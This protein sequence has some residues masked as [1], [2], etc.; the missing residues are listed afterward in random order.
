MKPHVKY[1]LHLGLVCAVLYIVKSYIQASGVHGL[2]TLL[3]YIGIAFIIN[4]GVKERRAQ[5]HGNL[6]Y[7]E[8]FGTGM[9]ITLIGSAIASVAF[10]INLKFFNRDFFSQDAVIKARERVEDMFADKFSDDE[11]QHYMDISTGPGA[12]SFGPFLEILITGLIVSLI[13]AAI[14]KHG[15]KNPMLGDNHNNPGMRA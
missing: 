6:T 4:L 9:L 8:G 7:G 10:Y 14:F 11:L 2:L 13:V 5:Q 12:I 3:T 1:G 15:E